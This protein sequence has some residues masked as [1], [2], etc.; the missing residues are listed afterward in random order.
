LKTGLQIP[1][2]YPTAG[3]VLR[4]ETKETYCRAVFM[5]LTSVGKAQTYFTLHLFRSEVKLKGKDP[6]H[7]R[8]QERGGGR[9][10][11]ID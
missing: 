1:L 6:S 4:I 10:I 11:K 5:N 7:K 8:M 9:N 3:A 2:G